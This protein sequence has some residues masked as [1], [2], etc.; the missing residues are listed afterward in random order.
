MGK[1]MR[2]AATVVLAIAMTVPAVSNV[3]AGAYTGKQQVMGRTVQLV[4]VDTDDYGLEIKAVSA[5][6]QVGATEPLAQLAERNGALVAMNGGYFNAYSDGQPLTVVRSDGQFVHN[7]SFGAVFGVDAV[8]KPYFGRI[9]PTIE[10]STSGSWVWPNNWSAWGINHYYDNPDAISILTP[11]AKP[12]T[13]NGGKTVVV[14]NGVVSNIVSGHAAIPANGYLVHFGANAASSANV[15]QVG[16]KVDYKISYKN[17]AG[18]PTDLARYTNMMGGGPLLLS[19]GAVVVDPVAERFTDPKQVSRD[20]RATRTFIGMMPDQRLVFG[21]VPN[22]SVYE[23]ADACKALGLVHAV[24]MDSGASAGLYA[25]GSYLTQPGRNIANAVVVKLRNKNA[26]GNRSGFVDVENGHVAE[27][28]VRHLREK[29]ITNGT[30]EANQAFFNPDK[31]LSR[32]EFAVLLTRA[33]GLPQTT[34]HTFA[35]AMGSWYDGHAGAVVKA[36]Y[37]NGYSTTEFG[38]QGPVTQEQVVAVMARILDKQGVKATEPDKW[39]SKAPSSWAE[40]EVHLG[41]KQGLLVDSFGDGTFD[42]QA[43]AKRSG[44]AMLLDLAMQKLGK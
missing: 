1:K 38:G 4:Y 42:P 29:G 24:G 21:T 41:I 2:L 33:M 9:Y 28:A 10:G 17:S 5:Q 11:Q 16:E 20:S 39:L 37:M 31:S 36:G 34:S 30:V 26:T 8:N 27:T 15:F 6:G 25:Y 43:A 32:A 18:V 22:V 40:K 19:G 23:L 35:D 12:R 44:M 7:G 13:L 14:Q 3:E